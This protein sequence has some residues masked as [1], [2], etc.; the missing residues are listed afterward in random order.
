VG[1]YQCIGN[2]ITMCLLINETIIM[3]S[4]EILN[5]VYPSSLGFPSLGATYLSEVATPGL[6]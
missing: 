6:Y 1:Y 4:S 5:D 3:I 2:P